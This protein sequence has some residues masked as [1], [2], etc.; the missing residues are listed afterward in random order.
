MNIL[1]NL[2]NPTERMKYDYRTSRYEVSCE[3]D[4]PDFKELVEELDDKGE[5]S[6]E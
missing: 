2:K 1:K 4:D 5:D 3:E 6:E